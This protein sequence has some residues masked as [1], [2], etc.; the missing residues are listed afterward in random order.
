MN[1]TLR[2][3]LEKRSESIAK[4]RAILTAAEGRALTTD[5][6]QQYDGFDKEVDA[7]GERIRTE[8]KQEQR[9]R[10][11]SEAFNPG[12]NPGRQRQPG[13]GTGT[14]ERQNTPEYRKHLARYLMGAGMDES[15]ISDRENR[16]VLGVN[17]GVPS[18]GGVLAPTELERLSVKYLQDT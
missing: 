2:K 6:Q 4:A 3:L 12:L 17:L 14:E 9:E 15:L 1:E 10:E 11:M 7:L 13:N 18:S 5:E 16:A 8:E